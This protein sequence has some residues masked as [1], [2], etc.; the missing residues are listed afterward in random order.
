MRRSSGRALHESSSALLDYYLMRSTKTHPRSS[1]ENGPSH[2]RVKDAL[3][4]AFTLQQP[5]LRIDAGFAGEVVARRNRLMQAKL[6]QKHPQLRPLPPAPVPE[7]ANRRVVVRS[8][9]QSVGRTCTVPCRSI[10]GGDGLLVRTRWQRTRRTTCWNS[11]NR[12]GRAGR[13]GR[14]RSWPGAGS[15][16]QAQ[17]FRPP[18]LR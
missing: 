7:Y 1:H 18:L 14:L 4:Q 5:G 10:G 16:A 6:G 17:G 3:D 13:P 9:I 15:G 2:H 8:A 12:W 11:W